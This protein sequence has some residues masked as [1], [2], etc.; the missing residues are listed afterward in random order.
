VFEIQNIGTVAAPI[1]TTAPTTLVN[2]NDTND[3][4]HDGLIVD[5][6]GDLFGTTNG[7]GA[8]GDGTVFEIS[9]AFLIAPALA[10]TISGTIG[11][12]TTTSETPVKPFARAT[13]GDVNN[14]ATDTLTITLGGVG[15][16][17]AD[18]TGFSNLTT[19]GAGVYRLSGTAAAITSELDALVFT[20]REGASNASSTTTFTLSDQSSAGGAPVVDTTTTVINKDIVYPGATVNAYNGYS[21]NMMNLN[22]SNEA[23]YGTARWINSNLDIN[24]TTYPSA[25]SVEMNI[26]GTLYGD[27]FAGNFS[28]DASGA[29]TGGRVSAYSESVWN[30]SAW[31]LANSVT[32]FSYSAV[33][34]YDAAI[35]GVRSDTSRIEVNILSGNDTVTGSTGNDILYGGIGN[36]VINGG[37]GIDTAEYAGNRG[38]YTIFRNADGS[39][40]VIDNNNN[41]GDGTDTLYNISYLAFTDQTVALNNVAAPHVDFNGDSL[42]DILW[43]NTSGQ[44]SIWEMNGN[45]LIGGGA[46]SPNP[47]P[48]WKEIGTGDFNGDGHA[49]ILFQNTSSGQASIWEMRQHLNWRGSRQPQSRA[50]LARRWDGRFQ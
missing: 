47:G 29:V 35:S 20:P 4:S 33:D 43:Q 50:E 15:G 44:A 14:G 46:V 38:D 31:V 18:G 9:G 1:Y 37:G 48:A 39:T 16:T 13:V 30:G 49:D 2:F 27:T 26:N 5:A 36:D 23:Q 28:T 42:S 34:F 3:N 10:P 41:V 17:L 40:S 25:Y 12:Q 7:G 22:L 24:G 19:V 21:L 45:S 8:Y 11:G 32:G 6:N